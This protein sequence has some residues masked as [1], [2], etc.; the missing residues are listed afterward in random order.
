MLFD[1]ISN[2]ISE[3]LIIKIAKGKIEEGQEL[4]DEEKDRILQKIYSSNKENLQSARKYMDTKAN[5]AF[6]VVS[7]IAG[8]NGQRMKGYATAAKTVNK[9][10]KENKDNHR[11]VQRGLNITAGN[12]TMENFETLIAQYEAADEYQISFLDYFMAFKAVND[13]YKKDYAAPI[14][15]EH[16]VTMREKRA[17]IITLSKKYQTKKNTD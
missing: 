11:L 14:G 12:Q 15:E 9:G 10:I 17:E 16:A 5:L 3:L 1:E 7:I 6:K 8:L 13:S 2:M 4:T